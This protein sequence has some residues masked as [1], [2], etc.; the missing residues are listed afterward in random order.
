L[1]GGHSLARATARVVENWL[2]PFF[3]R[4]AEVC[5]EPPDY[6][7]KGGCAVVEIWFEP[8]RNHR[9]QRL[10]FQSAGFKGG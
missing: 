4:A 10:S 9:C 7:L 5:F 8:F 3:N 1:L 6:Y 2:P